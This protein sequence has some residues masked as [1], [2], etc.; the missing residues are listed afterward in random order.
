M[1]RTWDG[2]DEK[3]NREAFGMTITV[4]NAGMLTA[5]FGSTAI[6]AVSIYP[7]SAADNA[8]ED[9]LQIEEVVVTAR[10]RNETSNDV[11]VSLT[12]LD[13]RDLTRLGV[14]SITDL[15]NFVPSMHHSNRANNN[16]QITIRGVGG[17]VRNIGIESGVGVYI[18]GVFV[19]RTNAY[20]SDL[21][22]IESIEVLRGP[23][24]TLFG[25]NTIGGAVVINTKKPGDEFEGKVT[26]S[27]GKYNAVR[28]VGSVSAP[29]ADNFFGKLT[30]SKW[31]RDGWVTNLFNGEDLQQID[32]YGARVQLRWLPLNNLEINFS[33]DQSG[34]EGRSLF[35][36]VGDNQGIHA[37]FPFSSLPPNELRFLA[38]S[39]GINTTD[40]TL[41]GGSVQVDYE[42]D[43][44]GDLT[45]I[46]SF[47]EVRNNPNSDADQVP[48]TIL[49]VGPNF[50][51]DSDIWAQ[52][53]RYT[54]PDGRRL[55]YVGGLYFYS[56]D[57]SA[58]RDIPVGGA[59]LPNGIVQISAVDTTTLAAFIN[60]DF[61]VTEQFV[62]NGGLRV[63]DEDKSAD[64]FQSRPSATN[65]VYTFSDIPFGETALSW[66][67]GARFHWTDEVNTY[68]AISRGFKAGGYNLDATGSEPVPLVAEDFIFGSEYLTNYEIGIKGTFWE[69]RLLA[70]AALFY[71]DYSNRQVN[72]F[73]DIPGEA[74]PVFRITNAG[75]SEV[76]GAELELT[77]LLNQYLTFRG[78]FSYL[79]GEYTSFEG[80][81]PGGESFTGNTMERAPKFSGSLA[82]IAEVPVEWGILSASVDLAFKDDVHLQPSN[83]SRFFESGYHSLNA[84]VGWTSPSDKLQV[85]FWFK[86][87][88]NEVWVEFARPFGGG[89]QVVWGEP[90]FYGGEVSFKF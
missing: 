81:G 72:Q 80:A 75:A 58:V 30:L 32:R 9:A 68:L 84:R 77:A 16:N 82:L 5:L 6:G 22:D 26:A 21:A 47:R 69:R 17:D 36:Q 2:S 29:L 4:T 14:N 64:H 79:D 8:V 45:S 20:N 59:L 90:R 70:T 43:S 52:E 25:K 62:L 10:K 24:G 38:N 33:A 73:L 57:T 71:S 53:L 35:N 66:T 60:A 31:D 55:T 74:V 48:I 67:I 88:T 12:A 89:T 34:D 7:A 11:P 87:L 42:L 51:D 41:R 61:R 86:N 13:D 50:T 63:T 46:T 15:K 39:N 27:F 18:D 78:A 19:G 1:L 56:Q 44:G 3:A 76:R 40:R 23:Q 54:S 85:S 83:D 49:D 65:G 28:L 37:S